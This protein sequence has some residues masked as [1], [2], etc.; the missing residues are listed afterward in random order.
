MAMLRIDEVRYRTGHRSKTSV[1]NAVRAGVFTK[2]VPI[3]QRTTGWPDYEVDAL[4][5]ARIAGKSTEE[6]H[7]LVVQFHSLRAELFKALVPPSPNLTTVKTLF[8][9]RGR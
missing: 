3:G 5:A 1:Y 4:V 9:T 8:D 7:T 2:P 6:I